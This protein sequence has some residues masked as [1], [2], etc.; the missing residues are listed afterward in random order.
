MLARLNFVSQ[1]ES[2]NA[3]WA[4]ENLN[5]IRCL[6]EQ[7]SVYRRAMA[8]V[9]IVVGLIGLAATGLAQTVDWAGPFCRLL[10]RSSFCGGDGGPVVD[11]ATSTEQQGGFLVPTHSPRGT[12]ID[13]AAYSRFGTRFVGDSESTGCSGQYSPDSTLDHPV[14]RSVACGG[15]L[16]ASRHQVVGLDFCHYWLFMPL[17]SR[18]GTNAMA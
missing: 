16:H 13:T 12:G 4:E 17:F 2:V 1:S 18:V 8:P 10:A 14:W 3:N 15:I 5:T 11:P 7:A 6:M 9:A